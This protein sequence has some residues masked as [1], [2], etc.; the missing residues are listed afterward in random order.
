MLSSCCSESEFEVRQEGSVLVVHRCLARE[1]IELDWFG[2]AKATF[3]PLC[4]VPKV[5]GKRLGK[6]MRRVISQKPRAG[7][8][9]APG[10]KVKLKVSKGKKP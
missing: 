3:K 6:A 7:T 4:V 9:R 1:H 10:A 2:S 8:K 5:K